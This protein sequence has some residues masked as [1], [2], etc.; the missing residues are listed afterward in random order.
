MKYKCCLY[1]INTESIHL[2][3]VCGPQLDI[4][5]Q[6]LNDRNKSTRSTSVFSTNE[7][8]LQ[9][10]WLSS[11]S[12][13]PFFALIGWRDLCQRVLSD[14]VQTHKRTFM[15]LGR[16]APVVDDTAVLLRVGPV[17]FAHFVPVLRPNVAAFL[18][19]TAQE[20]RPSS[21]AIFP[22]VWFRLRPFGLYRG[23]EHVCVTELFPQR[24]ALSH[25]VITKE[26]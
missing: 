5:S 6:N 15:G 26:H 21:D 19:K 8:I 20:R 12:I 7:Y 3:D 16:I 11:L 1:Q 23:E 10:H 18:L 25:N 2:D 9:Y 14:Y 4:I 13:K 24:H 17:E 22:L